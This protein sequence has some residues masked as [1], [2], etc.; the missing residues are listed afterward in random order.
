MFSL[1]LNYINLFYTCGAGI[2]RGCGQDDRSLI[3]ERGKRF[4]FFLHRVQTCSVANPAVHSP[5][6]SAETSNR[7]A[8][9]PLR[10]ISSWHNASLVKRREKF[11]FCFYIFYV[12]LHT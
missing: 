12:S 2:A 8:I 5:S 9:P 1:L 4:F 6:S 3:P 10:H 11:S 7:G